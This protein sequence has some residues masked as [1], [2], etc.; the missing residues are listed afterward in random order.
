ME[1]KL[2]IGTATIKDFLTHKAK[3]LI[4]EATYDD[5]IWEMDDTKKRYVAKGF[6]M[7]S[8]GKGEEAAIINMVDH[9]TLLDGSIV[10]PTEEFLN[11]DTMLADD[12]DELYKAINKITS[13]KI[14]NA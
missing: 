10:K 2:S 7:T 1:V 6:K 8:Q 11:G 14:P 9:F 12:F 4:S 3:K 5:V 13:K